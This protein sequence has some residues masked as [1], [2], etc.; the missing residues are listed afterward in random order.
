MLSH[1]AVSHT[2]EPEAGVGGDGPLYPPLYSVVHDPSVLCDEHGG[3][4]LGGNP[5]PDHQRNPGK[6][7]RA[8]RTL[9]SHLRNGQ[10][11][12]FAAVK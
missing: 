1:P 8:S 4:D 12:D 9:A 10:C 5:A 7:G 11:A 3:L 2:G 6:P